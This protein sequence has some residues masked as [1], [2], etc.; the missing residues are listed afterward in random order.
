MI[1]HCSYGMKNAI[2]P[3]ESFSIMCVRATTITTVLFVLAASSS[4]REIDTGR[5]PPEILRFSLTNGLSVSLIRV[6]DEPIVSVYTYYP[7]GTL[8]DEAEHTL[9][10]RLIERLS[11]QT[12]GEC[13]GGTG[14]NHCR[15]DSWG[16]PQ[17]WRDT[18]QSH[19]GIMAG[20]DFT[21]EQ[22]DVYKED[23]IVGT[24]FLDMELRAHNFAMGA[25][26][27]A[28]RYGRTDVHITREI[29]SAELRDV[30]AYRDQRWQ[31][32][33]GARLCIVSDVPMETMKDAVVEL[34]RSLPAR[35]VDPPA[36]TRLRP[37]PLRVSW[38]YRSCHLIL[39]WHIDAPSPRERAALR[40]AG[41][42]L[43]QNW[44]GDSLG[45]ILAFH[46]ERSPDGNLF[47]VNVAAGSEDSADYERAVLFRLL[48]QLRDGEDD[49]FR[50][51]EVVRE[52]LQVDLLLPFVPLLI[53]QLPEDSGGD[54]VFH[55]LRERRQRWCMYE[56]YYGDRRTVLGEHVATMT[57]DD[58]RAAVQKYLKFEE[59]TICTVVPRG[60]WA[61]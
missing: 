22:L 19:A 47:V 54:S 44:D 25:F 10:A 50:N 42:L 53:H 37:G 33:S 39:A 12:Y 59:C 55:L 28:Y 43:M 21:Q 13:D 52:P 61:K 40:L 49:A 9:W 11:T 24:R 20:V 56:W 18:L 1:S 58:I 51:I 14:A 23:V 30:R 4:A 7:G 31:A 60:D 46:E 27:Q 34:F 26:A 15:L 57:R 29:R 41:E 36:Q 16:R 17:Q 35:R 8:A 38:D 2:L 3:Q 6:A 32:L 48:Q 45:P 5:P